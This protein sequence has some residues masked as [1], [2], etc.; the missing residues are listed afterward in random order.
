MSAD[1]LILPTVRIER[2]EKPRRAIEFMPE[3]MFHGFR[4][5]A[6]DFEKENRL[7]TAIAIRA[8]ADEIEKYRTEFARA[9][10]IVNEA[11]RALALAQLKVSALLLAAEK[12]LPAIAANDLAALQ[13][14]ADELHAAIKLAKG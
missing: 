3:D 5:I 2:S 4:T 9:V 10:V 11:N 14:L 8:L 13:I 6:D 7:G 1:I 12:M